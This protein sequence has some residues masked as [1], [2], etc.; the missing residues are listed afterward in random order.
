MPAEIAL[1]A[2]TRPLGRLVFHS[3]TLSTHL[4][5]QLDRTGILACS[6]SEADSCPSPYFHI[7]YTLPSELRDI[8]YQNERVVYN[9]MKAAA[10]TMLRQRLPIPTTRVFLTSLAA[11]SVRRIFEPSA[12]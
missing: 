8:A 11:P 1:A 12:K 3:F 9:L 5:K 7:V 10:E 6:R 2:R 4:S